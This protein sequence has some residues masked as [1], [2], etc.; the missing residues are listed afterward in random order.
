MMA[1][2]ELSNFAVA[3]SG[4]YERFVEVKGKRYHHLLN[5]RT[6]YPAPLCQSVTVLAPTAE[7]ADAWATYLFI[8]G[9]ETYRRLALPGSPTALFVDANGKIHW[10]TTWEK[11]YHLQFLD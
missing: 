4:D 1:S 9:F 6:G 8:I 7:E 11:S 3:T 10:E 2:F 5:P